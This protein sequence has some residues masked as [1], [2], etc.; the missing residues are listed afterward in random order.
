MLFAGVPRGS[1]THTRES[2]PSQPPPLACAK[3][4]GQKQLGLFT[5][6]RQT[7]PPPLRAAQGRVGEGCFWR[8]FCV[9]VER[10][11]AKRPPPSLPLG[12]AKGEGQKQLGLFAAQWQ[13]RP[14]PLRAAQGRVGEGCFWRE[15]CAV[16]EGMRAKRP[17]PGLP[18]GC[19]KGEGRSEEAWSRLKAG[20]PRPS[21]VR[22]PRAPRSG[23]RRPPT[24]ARNAAARRG[25]HRRRCGRPSSAPRG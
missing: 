7:Q 5:A 1:G 2:T 21:S 16:V 10:M 6:Q 13:T 15:F 25:R 18:L 23:R 22:H 11:R 4:E 19:A 17:R 24:A 12:C 3:G 14:P 8:E 20:P 9:V